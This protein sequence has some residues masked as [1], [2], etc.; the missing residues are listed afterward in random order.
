MSIA[1]IVHGGAG[2]IKAERFAQAQ[3]GCKE[4]AA[5]GWSVLQQGGSALDAVEAA[6]RALETNPN[7]N[8]GTGSCL[9]IAGNIEMDAGIMDGSTLNVGAIAGVELI[10]HPI[11]LARRVMES[12]HAFLIQEGAQQFA[13]E[14]GIPACRFEDLLTE[15]QYT[16]WKEGNTNAAALTYTAKET[17]KNSNSN[18]KDSNDTT[19]KHGTVG[20]VAIDSEGHLA[21]ATSTGGILNKYPG[22]VGDSPLIGCGF[23][24]DEYAAISCTGYGEDFIRLMIAHRAATAVAHGADAQEA[25][26]KT[27]EFLSQHAEGTGGLIIVDRNGKVG[28]AKNSQHLAYAS[29]TEDNAANEPQAGI[30]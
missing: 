12:E 27:I 20:A 4:A 21:A 23:Y 7:F 3:Q 19:S 1:L 29:I 9:N 26:Q 25:A 10:Q 5:I 14:Q 22:R 17:D 18:G 13:R 15:R 8:A 16:A 11:T 2:N 6:V 30:D 28:K 24:A